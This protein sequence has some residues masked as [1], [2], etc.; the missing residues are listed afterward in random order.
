MDRHRRFLAMLTALSLVCVVLQAVT[1]LS[2]LV[3]HLT[4]LFLIAALLL[5][6]HQSG[7]QY[8]AV[9]ELTVS[10]SLPE[11]QIDDLDLQTTKAGPRHYTVSGA[12]FGVA[13]DWTL[14][15]G[16][17]TSEFDLHTAKVGV[18]IE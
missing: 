4:P 9:K 10:A 18:P 15:V 16:A 13:G 8:D 2:E 17:R 6:G 14:E 5:S 3:L 7:A 1:G 12:S 11:K